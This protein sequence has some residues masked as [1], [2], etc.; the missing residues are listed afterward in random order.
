MSLTAEQRQRVMAVLEAHPRSEEVRRHLDALQAPEELHQFLLNYNSN[1]GVSP[2]RHIIRS[3]FCDK[4]TVLYAYWQFADWLWS[5]PERRRVNPDEHWDVGGLVGEIEA[6]ILAGSDRDER[7]AL[8]PRN[9]LGWD[10]IAEYRYRKLR[11]AGRLPFPPEMLEPTRGERVE[12][13]WL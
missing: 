11:E 9:Y 5:P 3:D 6:R 4:G 2:I 7:I 13:E 8:D 12:P 10:R 1:D